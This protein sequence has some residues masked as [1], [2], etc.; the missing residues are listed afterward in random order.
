MKAGNSSWQKYALW[1]ENLQAEKLNIQ[2]L[3]ENQLLRDKIYQVLDILEAT[4]SE[5]IF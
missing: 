5:K 4:I 3:K 1:L 2:F